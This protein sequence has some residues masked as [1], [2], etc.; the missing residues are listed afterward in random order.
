MTGVVLSW[1]RY[2]YCRLRWT[3]RSDAKLEMLWHLAQDYYR[4]GGCTRKL[5]R[6]N[7]GAA[8]EARPGS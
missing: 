8:L 5:M 7:Y 2:A 4:K 6:A 3:K 1:R